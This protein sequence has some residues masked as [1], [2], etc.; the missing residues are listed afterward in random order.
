MREGQPRR[1]NLYYAANLIGLS[2]IGYRL[3][4]IFLQAAPFGGAGLQFARRK[5]AESGSESRWPPRR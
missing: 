1:D 2:V 5:R 3:V 4:A